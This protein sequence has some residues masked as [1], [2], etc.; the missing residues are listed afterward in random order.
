MKRLILVI[1]L[2]LGVYFISIGHDKDG[3]MVKS[4]SITKV[5]QKKKMGICP[6]KDRVQAI[7]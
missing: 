2:I 5:T 6:C 1:S 7:C 4:A 3:V